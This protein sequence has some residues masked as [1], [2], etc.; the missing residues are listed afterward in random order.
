MPKISLGIVPDNPASFNSL[1]NRKG[2]GKVQLKGD[3]DSNKKEVQC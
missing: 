1:F 3:R 2:K